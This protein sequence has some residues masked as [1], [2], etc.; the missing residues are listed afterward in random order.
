MEGQQATANDALPKNM[1]TFWIIWGG[2]FISML[3]S[4]LTNFGLGVWIYEQTGRAT[5]FALTALF[6]T[7]PGLLLLPVGGAIADRHNRRLIMMLADTGAAIMTVLMALLLLSAKLE[8]W[9]IYVLAGLSSVFSAFQEPAYT[10]SITMLVPKKQLARAS[11]IMQMGQAIT[12]ILTPILAAVLYALIQLRGVILIDFATYFFAVGALLLVKIPQPKRDET[13]SSARPSLISDAAF[14]W[15]YIRKLPGLFALLIYFASVNF[16]LSL[17]GVL[18]GPLVLSYGTST[19][20]GFVQVA[21]SAALLIG[22]LLMSV[23]GGP[24]GKKVPALIGFIALAATGLMIS[25]LRANTFIVSLGRV[26][27][28]AFIPFAAAL[29][30]AIWQVKIPANLQGR[31]FSIRS[32]I[33]SSMTPIAFLLSGFMADHVFEPLMAQNGALANTSV[34]TALGVGPGRGIGLIFVVCCLFL[35]MESIIAISIPRIRNL[36]TDIPDTIIEAEPSAN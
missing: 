27:M 4:G 31:V 10:S 15:N 5:P 17:S 14:G 32:M 9:H 33:A 29:S 1:R 24:K 30:Q 13:A 11:G 26:V 25:G 12:G 2:Q 8:I 6:S 19:D 21:T 18:S 7:L 20:L 28:L 36:E 3:G 16:F 23:W 35:W 34:G 22:S